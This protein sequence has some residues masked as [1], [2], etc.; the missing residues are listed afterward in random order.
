M[1]EH[2]KASPLTWPAGWDRHITKIDSRFGKWQDR[3]TIA[4]ATRYVLKQLNMMG[5][6]D[7]N[8][9]ISSGLKL[10]QDGLPY[11]NQNAPEDVGISVWWMEG[12]VQQVIALDKYNSIADNLYAIGKTLDAVRGIERWGGGEILNRAFTGFI[13]LP[14]K[15]NN[16]RDVLGGSPK[17]LDEARSLYKIKRSESHPDKGG[18]AEL[19]NAFENA[20]NLA[21]EELNQVAG[22]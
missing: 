10:R 8:V 13:A 7:Y 9:I 22:D 1:E 21:K 15:L 18:T 20:W 2:I 16:W 6:P 5:V 19:F 4:K 12:K 11:S 17:N 3:V 14:D